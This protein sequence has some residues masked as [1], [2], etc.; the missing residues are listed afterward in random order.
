[1]LM[2]DMNM[3]N[4][5]GRK[6]GGGKMWKYCTQMYGNR[7]YISKYNFVTKSAQSN[8]RV[9]LATVYNI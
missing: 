8:Q 7:I 2:M 9:Y 5:Q 3:Q 4:V 1:M 6:E